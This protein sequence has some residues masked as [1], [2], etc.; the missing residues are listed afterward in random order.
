MHHVDARRKT[1]PSIRHQLILNPVVG[2]GQ[3]PARALQLADFSLPISR[4]PAA[5]SPADLATRQAL[6]HVVPNDRWRAL[7][8]L[9][10]AMIGEAQRRGRDVPPRSGASAPRSTG[11]DGGEPD[12]RSRRPTAPP[13]PTSAQVS[14]YPWWTLTTRAHP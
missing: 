4:L 13:R 6:P 9:G 11:G 14:T 10:E 12:R 7:D 5:S 1:H 3:E 2:G 8:R